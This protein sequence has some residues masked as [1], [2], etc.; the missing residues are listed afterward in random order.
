[1]SADAPHRLSSVNQAVHDQQLG[2][3]LS[4]EIRV[5]W[6]ECEV[7]RLGASPVNP[8]KFSLCKDTGF[9]VPVIR[10][11]RLEDLAGLAIRHA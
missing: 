1:M 5:T 6:F 2:L 7:G 10:L 8:Q 3:G 9:C 4:Q 11:G